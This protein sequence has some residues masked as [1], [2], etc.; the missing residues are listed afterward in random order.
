MRTRNPRAGAFTIVELLT[1]IA[2][3][4][5]LVSM[6]VP[7]LGRSKSMGQRTVCQGNRKF[8]GQATLAFAST[9]GGRAPGHVAGYTFGD[10]TQQL[11]GRGW[12]GSLNVEVLGQQRYWSGSQGTFIQ[13]M[14][15]D[16][17]PGR[18]YC[19]SI[20]F[21]SNPYPRAHMFNLDAAGGYTWGGQDA[22]GPYGIFVNPMPPPQGDDL[23]GSQ[24]LYYTL[25]AVLSNF[26]NPGQ[27][28]LV[29]ETETASDY[30]HANWPAAAP[31]TVPLN[32]PAY[33]DYP[34]YC[35]YGGAFAFRHVLPVSP[36]DYQARA[37]A[38]FLYIDGH[39]NT[40]TANDKINANDRFNYR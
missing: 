13:S 3:I 7:I 34:A 4:V 5:L 27:Q 23:V 16:P 6:L 1:V 24:W 22:A 17:S 33:P 2:I 28:F 36:R 30:I 10:P 29:V 19:P 18:V 14:G 12:V 39:V 40:L 35:A 11:R 15:Y 32:D 9:H 31:Y 25:G 8:I 38:N 20:K 21:F 26:P 37:T